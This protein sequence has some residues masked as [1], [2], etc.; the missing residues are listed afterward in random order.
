MSFQTNTVVIREGHAVPLYRGKNQGP[1]RFANSPDI[2]QILSDRVRS[3]ISNP[4]TPRYN[5]FIRSVTLDP[6]F[7]EDAE[8][9]LPNASILRTEHEP[10]SLCPSSSK[11]L[12][13]YGLVTK[14]VSF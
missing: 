4:D 2:T 6:A 5:Q 1:A 10:P 9:P 3:Q 7:F 14:Y 8:N 11:E 13:L 12:L